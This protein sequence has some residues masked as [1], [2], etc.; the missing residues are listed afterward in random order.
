MTSVLVNGYVCLYKC[1]SAH[2]PARLSMRVSPLTVCVIYGDQR[3]AYALQSERV[4]YGRR[5]VP[6]CLLVK[7]VVCIGSIYY[8]IQT[9]TIFIFFIAF[10]SSQL[11]S[12]I[13]NQWESTRVWIHVSGIKMSGFH[14]ILS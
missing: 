14:I 8:L 6:H 10:F 7:W 11:E 5:S 9:N 2:P 12:L 13:S 3:S 4:V 1:L